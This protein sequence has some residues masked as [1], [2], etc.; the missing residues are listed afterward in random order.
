MAS[1]VAKPGATATIDEEP[2]PDM[3]TSNVPMLILLAHLFD[4]QK[5]QQCTRD[6]WERGAAALQFCLSL[7]HIS[8]PTR[9][10]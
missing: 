3:L 1:V 7:I 10:Y 8:E 4:F 5:E 6:G 2:Q 9:P